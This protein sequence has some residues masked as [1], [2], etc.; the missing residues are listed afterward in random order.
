MTQNPDSGGSP[1][2]LP[3]GSVRALLTLV[4]IGTVC[5]MYLLGKEIPEKLQYFAG[6]AFLTYFASAGISPLF[7]ALRDG[8]QPEISSMSIAGE[9]SVAIAANASERLGYLEA[10]NE[11]LR[12]ELMPIRRARQVAE[13]QASES[14]LDGVSGGP[15]TGMAVPVP[16]DA[17]VE[18]TVTPQHADSFPPA[19]VIGSADP[20][21]PADSDPLRRFR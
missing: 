21:D 4:I 10:Q 8:V 15:A 14:R 17:K 18:L 11:G 9:R 12:N 2:G 7:T 20:E 6:I 3:E 16:A 19:P 13:L 5:A 1:L